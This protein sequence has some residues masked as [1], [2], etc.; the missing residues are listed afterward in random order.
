MANLK[1]ALLLLTGALIVLSAKYFE[2]QSALDSCTIN[3]D[4]F[5]SSLQRAQKEH[6]DYE[7]D[8][9]R[10]I[11]EKVRQIRELVDQKD[12]CDR[13]LNSERLKGKELQ[14]NLEDK[15]GKLNEANMEL[16]NLR[17]LDE[18][19]QTE[20]EEFEKKI[21]LQKDLVSDLN[22]LVKEL[23]AEVAQ[24]KT[25]NE[26]LEEEKTELKD[27][28]AKLKKKMAKVDADNVKLAAQLQNVEAILKEKENGTSDGKIATKEA[29]KTSDSENV[30]T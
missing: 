24:L 21:D 15:S 27:L 18:K 19:L 10:N 29:E 4:G 16:F 1:T 25:D 3:L 13:S 11:L 30:D 7:A 8:M 12:T 14:S 23:R 2:L 26:A 6:L 22:A 9:E 20:N 28:G 17:E 5:R